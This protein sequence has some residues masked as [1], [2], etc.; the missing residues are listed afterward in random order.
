MKTI[1][2]GNGLGDSLYVQAIARHLVRK[3]ERLQVCTSWPDVFSQLDV[4]TIPFRRN[5]VDIVAHYVQGKQNRDT[6]QFED[7]CLKAKITEPVELKLDWEPVGK[8]LG[9]EKPLI[10]VALPRQPM[11]RKDGYGNE[12]LPNCEVIQ[13]AIDQ[14]KVRATLVQVGA[15]KPKHELHGFDLDL[16]NKT[17]VCD[18]LDMAS[19]ADGFLGY[20]SFF[21]PL[22]ESFGKPLLS[23]WSSRGLRSE[24]LFIR[25]VRPKKLLHLQSS[26]YVMDDCQDHEL[27]AAVNEFL[28]Q[29]GNQG[30]IYEPHS[31]YSWE[32][33]FV[34]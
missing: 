25:L 19:V 28:E 2:G 8:V 34:A 29:A 14:L 16:S 9:F 1:R 11:D 32:R 13:R 3:G 30:K 22:A 4:E 7:C 18:L 15:G 5:G 24:H 33:P 10:L 31:S 17:T 12:L 27:T 26:K 6:T 21:I 23:V 20:C